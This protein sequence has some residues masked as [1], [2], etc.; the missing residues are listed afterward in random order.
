MGG[1]DVSDEKPS[2]EGIIAPQ[3]GYRGLKSYQMTEVVR[4]GNQQL[5]TASQLI[6]RW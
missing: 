3:G 2:G 1:G 6:S 4:D 5:K